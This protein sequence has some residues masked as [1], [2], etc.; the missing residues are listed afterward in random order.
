[1]PPHVIELQGPLAAVAAQ[2]VQEEDGDRLGVLVGAAVA[3]VEIAGRTA[4][5]ERLVASSSGSGSLRRAG[6]GASSAKS[7]RRRPAASTTV[8]PT[9]TRLSN[10]QSRPEERRGRG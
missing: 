8:S 9:V 7:S 10:I 2:A 6:S 1:M 5:P 4:Q 3:D